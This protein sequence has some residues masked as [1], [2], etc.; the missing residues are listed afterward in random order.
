MNIRNDFEQH[1]YLSAID[2]LPREK[3][4]Y[5]SEKCMAYIDS[6]K[7]HPDFSE[8]T[9]YR[10]ELVL[11]WVAEL[12][13]EESLLD[14]IEELIGPDILLWN[15]FLPVKPPRAKGYF[16]WHQDATYWPVTPTA[17]IVSAW[18]ALS[19]VDQFCGGMQMV[20]G[21]HLLGAFDHETT[22]DDSSMLKRGQQITTPIDNA[23]VFDIDL[24]PGQASVHH[25]LTLHRSGP[26]NSDDWRLGV[27]L[28]YA[29]AEVG[30]LPGY[31]DSAMPLRG[32]VEKSRFI[33]T[34]PPQSDLDAA[35]LG[36]FAAALQ[37]QS[38]RYSDVQDK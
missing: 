14:V 30:P 32:N 27:G 6:Y 35:A 8:W 18:V 33:F 5:Y 24:C 38:K 34:Q 37:R 2:V 13:S 20:R 17:K 7:S 16:G 4:R 15:A 9:Y 21:S 10:T 31:E 26:N 3:A 19:P 12:A 36:N 25:T 11:K 28:N 1:G 29:S 23:E 22:Y